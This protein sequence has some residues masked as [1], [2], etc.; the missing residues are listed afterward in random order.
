MNLYILKRKED[1][2]D[3][4][5]G[6]VIAAETLKQAREIAS[7]TIG[8]FQSDF[9]NPRLTTCKVINP[10]KRPRIILDSYLAG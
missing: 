5:I 6:F 7:K 8:D 2:Y 4:H 1:H 9:L 3:S 10:G